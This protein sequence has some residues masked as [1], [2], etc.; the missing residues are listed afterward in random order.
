VKKVNLLMQLNLQGFEF[1][2]GR[3][4][5]SGNVMTF[6]PERKL[7]EALVSCGAQTLYCSDVRATN[8]MS[9]RHGHV[10]VY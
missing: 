1:E 7:P 4:G 5:I 9:G 10:S 6:D 2:N 3:A 8:A